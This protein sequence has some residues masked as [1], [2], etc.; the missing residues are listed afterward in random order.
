MNTVELLS[1]VV[2]G[3]ATV[4]GVSAA[5]YVCLPVSLLNSAARHGRYAG[6]GMSAPRGDKPRGAAL[7][8]DIGVRLSGAMLR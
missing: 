2:L 3:L 1:V 6:L 7:L 5:I 4:A 8:A